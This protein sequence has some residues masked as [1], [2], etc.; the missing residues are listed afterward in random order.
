MGFLIIISKTNKPGAET[1]F[2]TL[3]RVSRLG[4]PKHTEP[5]FYSP[6]D[7]ILPHDTN[8]KPCF[9]IL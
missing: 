4:M 7:E 6:V 3:K 8:T 2:Q 1:L 9:E 5:V